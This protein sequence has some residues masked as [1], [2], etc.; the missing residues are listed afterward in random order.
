M[1]VAA[2]YTLYNL[3]TSLI[4]GIRNA[5]K[6]I[7]TAASEDG[8]G[9]RTEIDIDFKKTAIGVGYCR[10]WDLLPL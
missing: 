8:A 6:N 2:F 4:T 7:G 3:R 10:H 9:D 1:I 5:V